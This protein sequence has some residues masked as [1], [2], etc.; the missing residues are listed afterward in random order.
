MDRKDRAE[1][2]FLVL[3]TVEDD[4]HLCGSAASVFESMA[5]AHGSKTDVSRA[6]FHDFCKSVGREDSEPDLARKNILPF[7]SVRM[8]VEFTEAATFEIY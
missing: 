1:T 2:D 3:T 7:I 5:V 6:E 8:P 4:Q